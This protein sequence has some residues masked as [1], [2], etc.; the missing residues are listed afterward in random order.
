MAK[1]G[2]FFFISILMLVLVFGLVYAGITLTSNVGK[3]STQG[4]DRECRQRV[5]QAVCG[6]CAGNG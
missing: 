1:K 4:N 6:H 3:S 5:R 2:K